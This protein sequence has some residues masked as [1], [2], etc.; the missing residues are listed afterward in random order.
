M[1]RLI[2]ALIENLIIRDIIIWII[3][4][5]IKAEKLL[6][7]PAISKTATMGAINANELPR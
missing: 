4:K 5:I 6:N 3:P 1:E 7:F 2:H